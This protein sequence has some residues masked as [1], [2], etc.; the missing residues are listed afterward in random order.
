MTSLR[1]EAKTLADRESSYMMLDN[2]N[3][4]LGAALTAPGAL[5][6]LSLEC[7]HN[8]FCSTILLQA[9]LQEAS[10]AVFEIPTMRSVD[11]G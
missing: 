7:S 10:K 6:V 4:L 8:W 5:L 9:S 3:S 1:C 11:K 2:V